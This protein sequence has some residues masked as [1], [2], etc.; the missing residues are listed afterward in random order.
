MTSSTAERP[1]F[2]KNMLKVLNVFS[3]NFDI[4]SLS[5]LG[6]EYDYGTELVGTVALV[7]GLMLCPLLHLLVMRSKVLRQPSAVWFNA[8]DADGNGT[9][10]KTEFKVF[11]EKHL[12][13]KDADVE[14]L[15]IAI[16]TNG[17]GSIDVD[18]FDTF[19]KLARTDRRQDIQALVIRD[20]MMVV[21]LFHPFVSGLAMKAFKCKPVKSSL[22]AAGAA[23]GDE[24]FEVTWYVQ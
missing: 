8:L 12:K 14:D 19:L 18:E 11:L 24:D 6:F 13:L 23:L 5:C 9:L 16:D 20:A 17:D 3:F 7:A 2:V 15:L 21:L 22:F 1:T 4:M 10:D